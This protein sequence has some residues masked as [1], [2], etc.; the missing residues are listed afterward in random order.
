MESRLGRHSRLS[1]IALRAI[2]IFFG[3]QAMLFS[4]GRSA[5]RPEQCCYASAGV[6]SLRPGRCSRRWSGQRNT[7]TE[8]ASG[9]CRCCGEEPHRRGDWARVGLWRA[10]VAVE[11]GGRLK[12]RLSV[13]AHDEVRLRGL[14]WANGFAMAKAVR[15]GRRWGTARVAPPSLAAPRV[16]HRC[17]SPS[18]IV[19]VS[20]TASRVCRRCSL[21]GCDS[22]V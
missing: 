8:R 21:A 9:R 2:E 6:P 18:C 5:K 4:S 11:G 19:R 16:W 13:L 3:F 12:P 15:Q 14:G 20:S 1:G 10:V 17:L 7:E 22:I